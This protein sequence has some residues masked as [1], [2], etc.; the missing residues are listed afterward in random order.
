MVLPSIMALRRSVPGASPPEEIQGQNPQVSSGE[1]GPPGSAEVGVRVQGPESDG[2][3][4]PESSEAQSG[5][6]R[7]S[8]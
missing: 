7:G 2:W 6:Q 1:N 3:S 8:R 5:T 4:H